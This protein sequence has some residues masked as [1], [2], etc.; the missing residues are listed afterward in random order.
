MH[1][2]FEI[3]RSTRKC[4][5]TDRDLMPGDVCY[6][7]LKA[8]GAD[9]VRS[10][11]CLEAWSG[12]PE[13]AIGWWQS[14]IPEFTAK[15]IKL[16]PNDVL[17][18]LFDQLAEQPEN[19][20]MRYVLALLLVRRRVLRVETPLDS[21]GANAQVSHRDGP[22]E[23]MTLYCPKRDVNYCVSIAMPDGERIDQIQRQLSEWLLAEA[24]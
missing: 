22:G 18:K 11:Y 16:A 8:Q 15:K 5:A 24:A 14:R 7:V 17:L 12:P 1:I 2:D 20:D 3:Q 19:E 21:L 6:S 4:A 23:L 9:V 10:D 13:D